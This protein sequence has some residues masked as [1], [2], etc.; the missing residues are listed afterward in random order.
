MNE[1]PQFYTQETTGIRY[2]IGDLY[3]YPDSLIRART[4][5]AYKFAADQLSNRANNGIIVDY[6]SGRG[7][8]IPIIKQLCPKTIISIDKYEPYL[9]I[10][11]R[12]GLKNH[13]EEDRVQLVAAEAVPLAAG[14]VDTIFFMHVIEHIKNLQQTLRDMHCALRSGGNL[15]VATPDLKNLVGKSPYDEQ[16]YTEAELAGLLSEAGFSF[17]LF[18]GVPSELAWKVHRR[19]HWLAQHA[20]FTGKMRNHASP[21]LWDA[22]VLRSGI[23]LRELNTSDFTFENRPHPKGIDLLAIASKS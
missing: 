15:V 8:G 4:G 12:F 17:E 1:Q 19:K 22:L 11:Q 14:S 2:K 3:G 20:Q 6:G 7:H 13:G 9:S 18:Y 16:V 23:S 21:K 10:A 5:A